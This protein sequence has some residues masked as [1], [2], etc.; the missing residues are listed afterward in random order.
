MGN[1]GAK[2]LPGTS[3]KSFLSANRCTATTQ[4]PSWGGRTSAGVVC[5]G[6]RGP[7][8]RVG[9]DDGWGRP[10]LKRPIRRRLLLRCMVLQ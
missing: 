5:I 7:G 10:C 4:P 1:L 3:G 8:S 9:A 6:E 2:T